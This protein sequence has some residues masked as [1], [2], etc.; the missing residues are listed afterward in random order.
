M[1]ADK[2]KL[3]TLEYNIFMDMEQ[4]LNPVTNILIREKGARFEIHRETQENT[5]RGR[6]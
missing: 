3:R 1:F 6:P 5:Q 4:S 2:I